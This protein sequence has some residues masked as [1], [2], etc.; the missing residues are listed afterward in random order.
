MKLIRVLTPNGIRSSLPINIKGYDRLRVPNRIY[1]TLL[2]FYLFFQHYVMFVS[3]L[4]SVRGRPSWPAEPRATQGAL[5]LMGSL[6]GERSLDLRRAPRRN[7]S[8]RPP[9]QSDRISRRRCKEHRCVLHIQVRSCVGPESTST[10]FG[11]SAGDSPAK[12]V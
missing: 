8:D 10:Y 4:H 12:Q 11:N 5:A 7:R 3:R 2:Y 1:Q 9:N 6:P